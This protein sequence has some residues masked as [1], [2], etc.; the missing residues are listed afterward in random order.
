MLTDPSFLVIGAARQLA[1][2]VRA[3]RKVL[4]YM[5]G[6]G[7]VVKVTRKY[8]KWCCGKLLMLRDEMQRC[9]EDGLEWFLFSVNL[10]LR[11]EVF[12]I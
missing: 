9:M 12:Y 6:G 11:D 7:V 5:V 2:R 10:S 4:V 1:P 8:G 3:T